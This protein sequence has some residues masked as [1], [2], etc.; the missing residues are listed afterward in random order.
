MKKYHQNITINGVDQPAEFTNRVSSSFFNEGKWHN[1]IAKLLPPPDD[2]ADR[3]FIE[4]G[5]NVGLYLRMAEEYGF[6]RVVGV[7]KDLDN[8]IMAEKYR[9]SY[10]L[11]YRILARTVGEDF[12]W[13]E[14]PVADVVL[15][16]NMHYY[17]HM[18]DFVPFLDRMLHKTIYCIV[19]SRQMKEKK[20]GHPLPDREGIRNMF[21][22]WE[23][24]RVIETSSNMLN[25]DPHRRRLHSMLF[26]SKLE[27]QPISDYTTRTQRYVK[28]QE[29]IDIVNEDLRTEI[30]D[31]LNWQYWKQRKQEEKL[32]PKGRWTDD[33]IREH[34]KHRLDL[35]RS[36][37]KD[38]MKEP[39][40]VHPSRECIDGGNR[41]QILKLLGYN[42]IIVRKI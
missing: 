13:D 37:I 33:Q 21:R 14:L 8:C 27:R 15:L 35:V 20:H 10:N 1:F 23:L 6:R 36:M 17:I 9:D 12:S 11:N 25:G 30:E 7:E 42:S 4:I 41:A 16:S 31:S 28:Q 38:G 3:T 26:K 39:I 32:T 40:L 5:S 29:L 2:V 22:D 24:L 19:V 34:I 18:N